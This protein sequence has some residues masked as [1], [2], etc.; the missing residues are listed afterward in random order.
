MPARGDSASGRIS[1]RYTGVAV[2]TFEA[3]IPSR[4]LARGEVIKASDVTIE[5]RPKAEATADIVRTLQAAVGLATRR[6]LQAGLPMRNADLMKPQLVSR[7]EAVT[8][9]YE[10]PGIVLSMR[11]KALD[12][13]SE[14]DVINVLNIQ[15]KRTVQGTVVGPGRVKV[16]KVSPVVA[17][18]EPIVTGSVPRQPTTS[19]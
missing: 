8:L 4:P 2:A 15:S 13:G 7:D 11:G 6:P 17:S 19:P 14:G 3:V 12:A 18:T 16:Q 1:L 5:R 10:A 9:V